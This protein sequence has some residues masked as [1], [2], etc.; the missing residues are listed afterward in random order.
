MGPA[1]VDSVAD[2]MARRDRMRRNQALRI[3]VGADRSMPL[4]VTDVTA[5][6]PLGALLG[7]KAKAEPRPFGTPPG[8]VGELRPYQGRGA[9][10]LRFLGELGLGAILADDMGLGK[11]V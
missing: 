11:T 9:A 8:F 6:G 1:Q 5:D 7:G 4:P 3:A 2:L 10:W